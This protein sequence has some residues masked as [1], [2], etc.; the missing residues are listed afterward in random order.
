MWVWL[1]VGWEGS[2]Y[3]HKNLYWN[4]EFV[5]P[6]PGNI[7]LIDDDDDG[8]GGNNNYNNNGNIVKLKATKIYIIFRNLN[9]STF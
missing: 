2:A 7:C 5:C 6:R 8:G 4:Y 1:D 9:I 3:W